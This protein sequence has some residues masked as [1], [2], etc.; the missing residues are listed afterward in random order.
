MSDV[1]LGLRFEQAMSYALA[2]HGDSLGSS[3]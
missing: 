1:H 3:L 2:V